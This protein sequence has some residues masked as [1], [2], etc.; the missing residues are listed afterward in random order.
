MFLQGFSLCVTPPGINQEVDM[1]L[2][3]QILTGKGCEYFI[4][5]GFIF[6]FIVF[7]RFLNSQRKL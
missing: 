7:Y 1:Y 4:A 3:E 6:V 5:V 2:F